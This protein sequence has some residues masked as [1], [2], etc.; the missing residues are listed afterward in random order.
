MNH[1]FIF[2]IY[3]LF[4]FAIVVVINILLWSSIFYW[5]KFGCVIRCEVIVASQIHKRSR[6]VCA[7]K[8]HP[9]LHQISITIFWCNAP[10]IMMQLRTNFCNQQ[11]SASFR[12]NIVQKF[13]GCISEVRY[14]LHR[15]NLKFAKCDLWQSVIL[16][17][18]LLSSPEI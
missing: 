12:C 8:I 13:L 7:T 16:W 5:W 2:F 10:L 18:F 3:T 6:K 1:S 4:C 14:S 9:K 11:I 15:K 17:S